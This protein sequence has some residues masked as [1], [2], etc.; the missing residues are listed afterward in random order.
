LAEAYA[1]LWDSAS[2]DWQEPNGARLTKK[3]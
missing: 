3:A 2:E 1:Q